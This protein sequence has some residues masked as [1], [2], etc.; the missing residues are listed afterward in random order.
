M[1]RSIIK[2]MKLIAAAAAISVVLPASM[3]SAASV[4]DVVNKY[5]EATGGRAA[6]EGVKS[7][8]RTGEFMLVDMGMGAKLST[9]N[10]GGN[11]KQ[12]IEIEGMGEV[13][14]GITDGVVWQVHF[15]EG[16]SILEGDAADAV[17][18]QSVI[19]PYLDWKNNFASA[20][21][22]GE[23]DGATVVKFTGKDGKDTVVYFAND[24]GLI[25]KQEGEGLDGS[26]A[27][28]TV[29][30]YKEV[31]G[32]VFAHRQDIAGTMTVE[33]TFDSI[34]VNG[35]VSDD[36]FALPDVI[37]AML[38]EE[39]A[40]GVTA[41]QVMAMMDAD[42]DGKITL[43]EAPEQLAA[44]F[45]MVDMNGDGGIDLEEAQMIADFMGNQ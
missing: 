11:F 19:N 41:E 35:D 33:M 22:T 45:T 3:A 37:Q 18:Q 10:K 38:P 5:I 30:E 6:Q 26:A 28:I 31:V 42:G 1:Y 40:G 15:M 32:I 16:D 20:E 24:T 17:R 21:V 7:L 25:A 34:E 12:S 4:D 2:N 14:T 44:A 27:T 39:E 23:E 13:T 36:V 43:E 9:Y 29:S 8:A